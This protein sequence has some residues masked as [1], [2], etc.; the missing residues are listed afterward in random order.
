MAKVTEK[1]K[2]KNNKVN[3]CEYVCHWHQQW[4]R[5]GH[6]HVSLLKLWQPSE[7]NEHCFDRHCLGL[8][9]FMVRRASTL[10]GMSPK[11]FF[12]DFVFMLK[13]LG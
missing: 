3:L 10:I 2:K 9:V 5:H 4:H 7:F 1:K 6:R 8:P 13:T 11:N 12:E